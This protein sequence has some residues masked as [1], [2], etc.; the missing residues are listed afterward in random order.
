MTD[1]MT[2]TKPS[3]KKVIVGTE[4]T[5]QVVPGRRPELKYLEFGYI[6]GSNGRLRAQV[7]SGERGMA[8][9][10]G[11]HYHVCEMQFLYMLE[12]WIELEFHGRGLVRFNPGDTVLIPGGL[13][14]QEVRNADG[15]R[16]LEISVPADMGTVNCDPPSA[17]TKF[18]A[19]KLAT[20]TPETSTF[21]EGRRAFFKYRELG[22]T[23]ATGGR[24][25][26]QATST[27]QGL[28]QPTGWHYHT[29]EMQLVYMLKGWIDLEFEDGR[30]VRLEAGD[31]VLIPGGARHQEILTSPAFELLEVSLPAE[32][33]TVPCDVPAKFA[34]R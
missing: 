25:R 12:G 27:E 28:T 26:A 23:A 3:A 22:V 13:V 32:M 31:S 33:G 17:T 18:P 14:H 19:I 4:K 34:G 21:V 15:F 11:W 9:P 7:F 2:L 8:R 24:M 10:T 5:A 1:Q 16:L 20:A 6:D 30:A 29:C